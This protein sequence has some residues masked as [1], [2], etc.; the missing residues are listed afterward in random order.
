MPWVEFLLLL[1]LF[2]FLGVRDDDT[3]YIQ[4][5]VEVFDSSQ[6]FRESHSPTLIAAFPYFFRSPLS[7]SA[8][9]L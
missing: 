4:L 9:P 2:F 1:L 5:L 8:D 7:H 6:I 3:A